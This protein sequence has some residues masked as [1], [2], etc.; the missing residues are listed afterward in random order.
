LKLSTASRGESSILEEILVPNSLA[1]PA[2]A[3]GNARATEF[4]NQKGEDSM[5]T[6]DAYVKKLKAQIDEWS[7][8]LDKLEAKAKKTSADAKLEYETQIKALRQKYD[9]AK[10]RIT[11]I[12]QASEGSWEDLKQGVESAWGAFKQGLDKAKARFK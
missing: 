4:N 1:N 10:T 12:Q 11:E 7:A 2:Q 9:S 8:E 6:K 5:E 3:T